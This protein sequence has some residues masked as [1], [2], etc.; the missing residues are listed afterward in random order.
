MYIQNK[1]L[2]N[3][4]VFYTVRLN[5]LGDYKSMFDKGARVLFT[6]KEL[7]RF[8]IVA[9]KSGW[10][11]EKD[12]K[13]AKEINPTNIVYLATKPEDFELTIGPVLMYQPA[14]V[15]WNNPILNT[16]M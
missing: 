5:T 3:K 10:F 15:D 13:E 2:M 7:P 6:I 4:T 11:D 16:S 14:R 9:I 12:I 1:V 8:Q